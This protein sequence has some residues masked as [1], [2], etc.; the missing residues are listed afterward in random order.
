[1]SPS[2]VKR[3][4]KVRKKTRFILEQRNLQKAGRLSSLVF[5]VTLTD[6]LY[7]LFFYIIIIIIII[8]IFIINI[9]IVAAKVLLFFPIH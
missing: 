8:I 1:M 9:N 2:Q 5:C 7:H 3:K 4:F 6:A